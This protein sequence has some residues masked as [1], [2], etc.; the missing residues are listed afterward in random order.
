MCVY[1]SVHKHDFIGGLEKC[2]R[3]SVGNKIYKKYY[4][5]QKI[6]SIQSR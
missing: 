5:M 4:P 6:D 3:R 1:I 2:V